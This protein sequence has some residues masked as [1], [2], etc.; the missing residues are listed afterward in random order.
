MMRNRTEVGVVVLLVVLALVIRLSDLRLMEFKYDE[1]WLHEHIARHVAGHEFA[2][3][4]ITSS[5]HFASPPLAVYLL[6]LPVMWSR[7][8]LV[9]TGFVAVLNALAVGAAYRLGREVAG[10]RA[11]IFAA[12]LFAASPW[13]VVFSRKIWVQDLLPP[14]SCVAL[15][16]LVRL[17][18]RHRRTDSVTAAAALVLLP[19]L[20]MSALPLLAL[21]PA[22][23]WRQR[24]R[25]MSPWLAGIALGV[26]PLIPYGANQLA[27][28]FRDLRS[29]AA[30]PAARPAKL[31]LSLR[32]LTGF[33]WYAAIAGADGFEY[34][35]DRK[36]RRGDRIVL[37]GD[38]AEFRSEAPKRNWA[39]LVEWIGLLAG[40][41]LCCARGRLRSVAWPLLVW[42]ALPPLGAALLPRSP[43]IHYFVVT[44]PTQ[45]VLIGIALAELTGA[46][47]RVKTAAALLPVALV[48][49][50][51]VGNLRYIDAFNR[52]ISRAAGTRADYGIAYEYKR[53]VVD[54]IAQRYG[55]RR[56]YF[57]N[58]SLPDSFIG[59]GV[60][61]DLRYAYDYLL[62]CQGVNVVSQGDAQIVCALFNDR[63]PDSRVK[64][65]ASLRP[66][67]RV[68]F[69]PLVLYCFERHA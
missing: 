15:A 23:M 32:R 66:V 25:G 9:C 59:A 3:R 49:V 63:L 37:E 52:F 17:E 56:V 68:Q 8:P 14:L 51:V 4:G 2:T 64:F 6:S 30:V 21:L 62:R 31:G 35:L 10:R 61:E 34:L 38:G 36:V 42:A 12:L 43:L 69:G 40:V 67:E 5:F 27:S 45:F 16:S 1:A 57:E 7:N 33:R 13:A 53:R 50:I 55:G 39:T 19:Q 41:V 54:H 46:L 24:R 26:I 65:S 29:L 22:A 60:P 47:R 11:G 48:A 18:R 28:G 44:Y 20:H 58:F